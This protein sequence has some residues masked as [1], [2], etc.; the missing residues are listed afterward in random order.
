MSDRQRPGRRPAGVPG[1]RRDT[2]VSIPA[3]AGVDGEA[4]GMSAVA[5]HHVEDGPAGG[6]AVL[7]LGSLGSTTAMWDGQVPA[8]ARSFRVL[9]PDLRGHGGSPV[10]EGPYEIADLGADVVALLDRLGIASAHVAGL[11]LGGM[12]AMWL[13]VHAP[14]RVDALTLLCTSARLGPPD[15]WATRAAQVRADGTGAVAG[16]VVGRW[17]TPEFAA[18]NPE[19]VAR[20]RAMV[21]GT[22]DEGYAACCGAIERMDLTAELGAISAPVLTIAGAEDPATPPEHLDLIAGR[23]RGPVR[24]EVLSPGAH[25]VT[26]ERPEA[27]A[28]LLL[29]HLT[30]PPGFGVDST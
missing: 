29:G 3:G 20:L 28:R 12:T 30:E 24:R 14:D 6:P 8:L 18:A 15:A 17:V 16:S 2:L 9:R 11:S 27:V 19:T 1:D 22:P 7:L 13:A 10:P 25:L 5:L 4:T 23:V 26:V 21:A